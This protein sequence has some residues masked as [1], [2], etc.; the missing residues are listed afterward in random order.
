M[1]AWTALKCSTLNDTTLPFGVSED[2]KA[3]LSYVEA[4]IAGDDRNVVVYQ[5]I[6]HKDVPAGC[7][8]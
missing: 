2:A 3:A 5:V 1:S 7:I 4:K 6:F 8:V